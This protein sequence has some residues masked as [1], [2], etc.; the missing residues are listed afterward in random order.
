MLTLAEKILSQRANRDVRAGDLVVV[1]VDQVM[2]VD[3]IAGSFFKRLEQLGATPRYPEK[4]SIVI[5]HVAPAANIEVAK[6]QK[7]IREWGNKHGCRVFDV[8]RGICHQVLMEEGLSQPGGIVLGSDSHS[9]T[10]GAVAC[11]GSGMGATDIALAA[12]SGKTWLRVPESVKV[13]FT[14][15]FA[16]GVTA[17][18]AALEMIRI[19]T[20]DGA[21]Y[22]SVEIHLTNGAESLTRGERM[23][24][25]NLTVEAGAKCGLVVPSGE[26][27]EMYDVPNWLYPDANATYVR[28]VEIDL[29]TLTPRVSVPFYV[30]NV[31]EVS[32]IQ[33]KKLTKY[34]LVLAR[35]AGSRIYTTQPQC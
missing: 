2:V 15:T 12:A 33:G 7:D 3:S 1:E 22:M 27:L 10:Y 6:A 18:D 21:T 24:L 35:M 29:A 19:L 14:G 32:A 16:L 8:G 9:T 23:T 5:D 20:A 13:T 11:F 28:E 31:S 17:K 30:D 26:I 25:A 34:L 4:V